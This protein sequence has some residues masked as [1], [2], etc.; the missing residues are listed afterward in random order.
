MPHEL[1]GPWTR[2]RQ[3]V[4]AVLAVVACL[5]F[6]WKFLES[7][8]PPAT[9]L[10]DFFQ[11][12]ASARNYREGLPIYTEQTLTVPRYLGY[13]VRADDPYKF[14]RFNAHPPA[15]VLLALPLTSLS[16]P[17]AFL[18]WNLLTLAAMVMSFRWAAGQLNVRLS[19]WS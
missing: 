11:E 9:I 19:P 8:R 1:F 2:R 12:Y 17:D 18:V 15:S 10:L 13:E 7:I 6:G 4:W 16:Y 5:L 14:L 3:L